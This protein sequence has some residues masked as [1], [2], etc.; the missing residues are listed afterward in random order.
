MSKSA[1]TRLWKDEAPQLMSWR[2][3]ILFGWGNEH[4]E[5]QEKGKQSASFPMPE[6][7]KSSVVTANQKMW[8]LSRNSCFL[9]ITSTLRI[10][11]Y[12]KNCCT[13]FSQALTHTVSEKKSKTREKILSK[14]YFF[15]GKLEKERKKTYCTKVNTKIQRTHK[16]IWWIMKTSKILLKCKNRKTRSVDNCTFYFYL[17]FR[18][19]CHCLP[20]KHHLVGWN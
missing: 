15:C 20:S 10:R 18:R 8:A 9:V 13:V 17:K 5:P 3:S 4:S 6:Y 19:S 1:N 12:I 16:A 7:N 2:R 14:C 11:I